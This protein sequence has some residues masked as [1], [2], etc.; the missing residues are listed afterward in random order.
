MYA[1]VTTVNVQTG[2]MDEAIT[3]YRD[4]IDPVA[5]QQPGCTGGYPLTNQEM[6]KAISISLWESEA[7]MLAGE[8]NEFLQEQIAKVAHLVAALP[9]TEHYEVSVG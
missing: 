1:R 7:D 5:K 8:K 6:R 4:S 3:I 2:M 9:V